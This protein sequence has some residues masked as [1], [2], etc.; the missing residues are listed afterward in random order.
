MKKLL[1]LL[2]A[3]VMVLGLV[4]CGKTDAPAVDAPADKPAD[5]P[6]DEAPAESPILSR[7]EDADEALEW[8]KEQKWGKTYT[9]GFGS[10]NDSDPVAKVMGDRFVEWCGY[11]GIEVV[12][13]DNKSE[14]TTA[15]TNVQLMLN[16]GV[17]AIVE[18]NVDASVSGAVMD[19]CNEAGVPVVAID[20]PHEGATFF[21]ADN[22]LCGEMCG[23]YIA[24]AALDKWGDFDCLLL[25]DQ[26]VAGELPRQRVL[27]AVTGARKVIPDLPDEKIYNIDGGVS[28]DTAVTASAAFLQAHPDEKIA[29]V[30]LSAAMPVAM[31]S[32][33]ETAGRSD[34]VIIIGNNEDAFFG[35]NPEGSPWVAAI[36]FEL[37]NYGKWIAPLVREG[38]DTGVWPE[39]VYVEHNI[40]T[41]E[42][43][44]EL[45]PN[46]RADMEAGI[47]PK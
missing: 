42:N 22:Y 46:W 7:P 2:L 38:L 21:G 26:I 34:D 1:A 13:T 11:Y 15:V 20:I 24:Q 8:A 47:Y 36:T 18:F 37:V 9:I 41:H 12:R 29:V 3:L 39:N 6:A 32:A 25:M 45:F 10:L 33:A 28:L 27:Q 4:A 35:Y 44:D 17:D 30:C 23:E 31:M 14:G 5:A 40:L 43:M 19:M 16:Q